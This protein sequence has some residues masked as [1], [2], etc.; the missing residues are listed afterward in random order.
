M[1]DVPLHNDPSAAAN[2]V[3]RPT[4]HDGESAAQGTANTANTAH[5]AHAGAHRASSASAAP[6]ANGAGSTAELNGASLHGRIFREDGQPVPGA[7]LTLI[8]QRGHQIA[9]ANSAPD[10]HYTIDAPQ[11]DHCFLIASAAGHQPAAV[12]VTVTGQPQQ[13]DLTLAGVGELSGMVRT[14][15]RGSPVPGATIT[16]TDERGEVVATAISGGDGHYVCRGVVAGNYTVVAV[17]EHMRPSATALLVPESSNSLQHD[18]ELGSM[19]VLTGSAHAETGRA[20]EDI[21]ITVLDAAGDTTATTRTDHNGRYTVADLP[22][23]RY[24]IVARGYPPA[25]SQVSVSGDDVE[26]DVH[27][28]HETEDRP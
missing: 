14:V 9:R 8:D 23:G 10:G 6:N 4:T 15:G 2:N 26:H 12:D 28:A 3:A 19:A 18:I 27:L 16:V 11:P 5:A 17:A 7:A 1:K 25:T 20:V 22:E 24:T 13:L 21:H